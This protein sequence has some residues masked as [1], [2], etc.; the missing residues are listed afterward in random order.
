MGSAEDGDANGK[1]LC[2]SYAD[3]QDLKARCGSY[4]DQQDLKAGHISAFRIH[5]AIPELDVDSPRLSHIRRLRVGGR[6]GGSEGVVV[7]G[8]LESVVGRGGLEGVGGRGGSGGTRG[9]ES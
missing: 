8:S 9:G 2:D 1:H 3:Q 7:R 6:A 5:S 4:A